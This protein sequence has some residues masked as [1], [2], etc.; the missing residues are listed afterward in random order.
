MEMNFG[1]ELKWKNVHHV[2][3]DGKIFN[4]HRN[5]NTRY[6]N[7]INNYSNRITSSDGRAHEQRRTWP[8]KWEQ[9][10]KQVIHARGSRTHTK[11]RKEIVQIKFFFRWWR[12]FT[13][14]HLFFQLFSFSLVRFSLIRYHSIAVIM[15]V[16]S[17]R[18]LASATKPSHLH[19]SIITTNF[20]YSSFGAIRFIFIHSFIIDNNW[21]FR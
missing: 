9:I 18:L 20:T 21:T 2:Q 17:I 19:F 12:W 5:P 4:N 1:R 16:I 15:N 11:C 10:C 7:S 14:V 3:I 6:K 13:K 8:N